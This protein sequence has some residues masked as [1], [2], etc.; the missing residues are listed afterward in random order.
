MKK[1][2]VPIICQGIRQKIIEIAFKNKGSH[3]GCSLGIVEILVSLYFNVLKI[4]PQIPDGK[5]RDRFILS[6][7]HACLA[8]YATL[9][10]RGFFAEEKLDSYF[11][12]GSNI[13]GHITLGSLPG[14]EATAGS[15]GHGLSI[16]LGIA[17]AE[18]YQKTGAKVFVLAGDGE[19]EEGSV[20]EAIM[21][22]GNHN[23]NNLIL[24]IDYNNLQIMG[25]PSEISGL[26]NLADKIKAFGWNTVSVNGHN[27]DELNAILSQKNNRP[28]AVIAKTTK[29]KGVSFMENQAEWHSKPLNDE[30]YQ[31]AMEELKL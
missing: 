28:L 9:A 5:K 3:I 26:D 14:L 17:I 11:T 19:C 16:G 12:N 8:L 13:A 2:N 18:T 29:G 1:N 31:K 23:I 30:D 25:K 6:K 21:Y 27:I 24:I 22:A 20:W 7:G 15:L 4:D 10:K